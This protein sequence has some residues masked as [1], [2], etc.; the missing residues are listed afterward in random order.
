MI[1]ITKI[2]DKGSFDERLIRPHTV[3]SKSS[4][5]NHTTGF[6]QILPLTHHKST[7]RPTWGTRFE[8]GIAEFYKRF[9][10]R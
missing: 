8:R 2:C 4:T 3:Q 7:S 9:P 10:D 5:G 1:E 6:L